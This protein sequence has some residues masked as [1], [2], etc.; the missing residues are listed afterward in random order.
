MSAIIFSCSKKSEDQLSEN[1]GGGSACDTANMTYSANIQPLLQN[2]CYSCHGN[3]QINGGVT[4]DSYAGVK[5][6]AD[7]G[8]L[9]GVVTHSAG[10]PQMPQGAAKL[11]DCNINKIRSWINHGKLN[12]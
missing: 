3:G 9:I 8:K 10:F 11:S 1:S 2:N 5:A 12:N 6:V 4:L 7:N